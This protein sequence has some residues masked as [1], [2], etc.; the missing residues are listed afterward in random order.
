[1]RAV[2]ID[3][4]SISQEALGRRFGCSPAVAQKYLDV[5]EDE[6]LEFL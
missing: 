5:L 2:Y 1:M 3:D 4:P 6:P